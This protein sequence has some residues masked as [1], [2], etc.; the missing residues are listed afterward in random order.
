[1][2]VHWLVE[3]EIVRVT[4]SET[5]QVVV[6]TGGDDYWTAA[7]DSNTKSILV[8][9]LAAQAMKAKV[10]LKFNGADLIA[11]TVLSN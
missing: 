10:S 2:A 5:G 1:M 4:Q 8:T 6:N 3:Q 9:L 7:G 11:V